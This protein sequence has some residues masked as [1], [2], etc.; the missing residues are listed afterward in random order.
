MFGSVAAGA[1][2]GAAQRE[3]E[4][5]EMEAEHLAFLRAESEANIG[6]S[7]LQN[8]LASGKPGK[9]HGSN[10]H[11]EGVMNHGG[12]QATSDED[13]SDQ[14]GADVAE[15][16]A[17]IYRFDRRSDVEPNTEEELETFLESY[18]KE[19]LEFTRNMRPWRAKIFLLQ[20]AGGIIPFKMLD[21]LLLSSAYLSL[22][23]VEHAR[24]SQMKLSAPLS[25]ARTII[26]SKFLN[27][28]IM[29]VVLASIVLLCL[30]TDSS[31]LEQDFA[32]I[33]VAE[34]VSNSIFTV[35]II[36]QYLSMPKGFATATKDQISKFLKRLE[37][38][39]QILYT[40]SFSDAKAKRIKSGKQKVPE[41]HLL[42]S[43]PSERDLR[44]TGGVESRQSLALGDRVGTIERRSMSS[45]QVGNAESSNAPQLIFLD[46]A[47]VRWAWLLIDVL[48]TLP[49]LLE[50]AI[51][52]A[53]TFPKGESFTDLLH[54]M[55]S[56]NGS[57]EFIRVIRLFRVLRL[58]KIGQKSGRVRVIWKA[59]VN[60]ADGIFLLFMIVPLFVIFFSFLLFYIELAQATVVDGVWYYSNGDVSPFQSVADC[61]WLVIVTL[62]T[63]GY[64]DLVPVTSGGKVLLAVRAYSAQ[65]AFT[66][67]LG[68]YAMINGASELR[69]R[70]GSKATDILFQR[71]SSTFQHID[72]ENEGSTSTMTM[73]GKKVLDSLN[74]A[75]GRPSSGG[76]ASNDN[77]DENEASTS[78]ITILG[79]KLMQKFNESAK[80]ISLQG[81]DIKKGEG[82]PISLQ[83]LFSPAVIENVEPESAPQS[84]ASSHNP[85]ENW[86]FS[87]N[88][89]FSNS[90]TP[91]RTSV[92]FLNSSVSMGSSSSM[93][94][95]SS[96]KPSDFRSSQYSSTGA[97]TA[98]MKQSETMLPPIPAAGNVTGVRDVERQI[99]LRS[100]D[101]PKQ[102]VI[103]VQDWRKDTKA[104]RRDDVMTMRIRCNEE[105]AY[106]RL[107]R[108]LADL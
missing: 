28:F 35:E 21:P 56:W 85:D 57:P 88:F 91:K 76:V 49:F 52:S 86:R 63:V 71:P 40:I 36:L 77:L 39:Y 18:L 42:R 6:A 8:R 81:N 99:D 5:E 13:V 47:S 59:V 100:G 17:D 44:E 106:R 67:F 14:P 80:T 53:E 83:T 24:F 9:A 62:T 10:G 15:V 68:G 82:P 94:S 101:L 7:A 16:D 79:K 98:G 61:F 43:R 29:L 20:T 34:C 41:L 11:A 84:K 87:S 1:A 95:A 54:R 74:N 4:D 102:V 27:A 78:T 75:L 2:A 33:F 92:E 69:A 72:N 96:S 103:K 73:I 31:L 51:Y 26:I 90:S 70:A 108:A 19:M 3:Y 97:N 12:A 32:K 105:D 38:I 89:E 25:V 65:I 22:S 46:D 45:V 48:A 93:Y 58:F 104:E 55:Y 66:Q 60:S 64:G 107:M 37:K 23:P 50:V 30:E